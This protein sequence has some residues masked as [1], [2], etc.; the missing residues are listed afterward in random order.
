MIHLLPAKLPD[1]MQTIGQSGEG[2]YSERS[3]KFYAFA[4]KIDHES[5]A[6]L[7]RDLL[8]KEHHKAVHVVMAWR[9]GP[10]GENEFATDDGEPSGSAGR[11]VLNEL[12]SRNL[13]QT[14]VLVVR[15]YG[16][17]KLGVPG[18]INAYRLAAAYA[19]DHAGTVEF[20]VRRYFQITCNQEHQHLVM[21]VLSEDSIRME[22]ATYGSTC[23]FILSARKDNAAIFPKLQSIWQVTTAELPNF[24]L[25][26]SC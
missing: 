10:E 25:P 20:E 26:E 15:Y 8:Q 24:S 19:L 7:M 2:S 9:L 4:I 18:L 22:S 14:A 3:S 21:Q 6:R 12:R 5:D 11:P 13:T 16:G 1:Y 17:K 23:S